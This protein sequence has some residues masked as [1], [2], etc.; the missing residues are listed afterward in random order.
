MHCV[1]GLVLPLAQD[2]KNEGPVIHVG[3]IP[4]EGP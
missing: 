3:T 4:T 2:T 1:C